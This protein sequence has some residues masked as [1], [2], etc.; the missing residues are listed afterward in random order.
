MKRQKIWKIMLPNMSFH[1]RSERDMKRSET[2]FSRFRG[3]Y[4]LKL[5]LGKVNGFRNFQ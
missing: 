1:H 3:L 2:I 4:G 5:K